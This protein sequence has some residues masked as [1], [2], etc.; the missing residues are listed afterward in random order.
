M[1]RQKAKEINTPTLKTSHVGTKT[2][3]KSITI[4]HREINWIPITHT[5]KAN[6]DVHSK[7]RSLPNRTQKPG[8]FRPSTQKNEAN[9]PA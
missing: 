5:K 6:F 2:K 7:T 4:P 8:Q 9:D 3:T 1:P